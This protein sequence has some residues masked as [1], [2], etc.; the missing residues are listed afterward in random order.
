MTAYDEKRT[1]KAP[2]ATE[3]LANLSYAAV[4]DHLADDVEWHLPLSLADGWSISNEQLSLT[5][6]CVVARGQVRLPNLLPHAVGR[7]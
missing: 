5:K 6:E 3:L 7:A 2:T 4:L 1:T